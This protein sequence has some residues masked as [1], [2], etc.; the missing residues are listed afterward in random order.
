MPEAKEAHNPDA[1]TSTAWADSMAELAT[2]NP[3]GTEA[4]PAKVEFHHDPE[5]VAEIQ[6]QYDR[7]VEDMVRAYE[8]ICAALDGQA[9][10][11]ATSLRVAG[12]DLNTLF[13]GES[14]LRDFSTDVL[15]R[16]QRLTQTNDLAVYLHSGRNGA[17]AQELPIGADVSDPQAAIVE[18]EGAQQLYFDQQNNFR[19]RMGNVNT[20]LNDSPGYLANFRREALSVGEDIQKLKNRENPPS[21]A[22]LSGM[23]ANYNLIMVKLELEVSRILSD[24]ERVYRQAT[25]DAYVSAANLEGRLQGYKHTVNHAAEAVGESAP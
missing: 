10:M 4:E 7:V 2:D 15:N 11:V 16:L 5:Q 24:V 9:E 3:H 6:Q 13:A 17:M 23:V 20:I 8:A 18:V 12:Q 21:A 22:E 25:T 1:D 14:A 19:Q